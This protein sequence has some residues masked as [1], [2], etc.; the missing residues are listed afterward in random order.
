MHINRLTRYSQWKHIILSSGSWKFSRIPNA[1][2][3]IPTQMIDSSLKLPSICQSNNAQSA[4][5]NFG[6]RTRGWPNALLA[7]SPDLT[8]SSTGPAGLPLIFCDRDELTSAQRSMRPDIVC[9]MFSDSSDG[10]MTQNLFDRKILTLHWESLQFGPPWSHGFL[11]QCQ[12]LPSL[13][14]ENN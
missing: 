7:L 14:L 12:R 2:D 10:T 4:I 8:G 13:S 5:M 6:T 1:W 9:S 3:E 11:T